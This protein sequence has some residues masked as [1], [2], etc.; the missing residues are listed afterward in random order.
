MLNKQKADELMKIKGESRGMNIKIDLD[1]VLEEKGEAGLKKVE[2]KIKELGYPL[3]YKKIR[4][5]DFYPIG[6][7]ATILLAIEE[8]FNLGGEELKKMGASVV[9]FSLL[10]KIF[11]KY[12]G[13]LNLVAKQIPGIW[14]EH[15]TVG[16]LEMP[17]FS[18][19]ERYAVLREKNFNIDHIYCKIHKGYFIKVAEMVVKKPVS[20]K[21]AK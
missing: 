9:K 12:L 10:M 20:C 18:D 16:S 15:Y 4:A 14:K 19:K 8:I 3:E 17:D 1:F 13:S 2:A 11:L 5:M 6:L 7:E 21:E